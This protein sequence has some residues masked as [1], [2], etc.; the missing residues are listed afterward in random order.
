MIN[1]HVAGFPVWVSRGNHVG[2]LLMFMT[3]AFQ[4]ILMVSPTNKNGKVND[5]RDFSSARKM[6][7]HLR[8]L[9]NAS[10]FCSFCITRHTVLTFVAVFYLTTICGKCRWFSLSLSLSWQYLERLLDCNRFVIGPSKAKSA[11]SGRIRRFSSCTLLSNMRNPR[12]YGDFLFHLNVVDISRSM[13]IP[14]H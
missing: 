8:Q 6:N 9:Q 1:L 5:W 11:G 14:E 13:Y 2:E 3:S 4:F 12:M 7:K 10:V